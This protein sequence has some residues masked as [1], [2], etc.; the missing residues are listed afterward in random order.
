MT[1]NVTGRAL[2]ST[3]KSIAT[4]KLMLNSPVNASQ[5]RRGIDEAIVVDI[6]TEEK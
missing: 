6:Y 3:V 5:V 1:R 4:I 2:A